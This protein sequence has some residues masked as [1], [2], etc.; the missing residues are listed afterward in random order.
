M[1]RS[2]QFIGTCIESSFSN[3]NGNTE[4]SFK[5]PINYILSHYKN[6]G[7]QYP[8]HLPGWVLFISISCLQLVLYYCNQPMLGLLT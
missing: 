4:M 8:P 1:Q 6:G 3:R 5:K 2:I 7:K